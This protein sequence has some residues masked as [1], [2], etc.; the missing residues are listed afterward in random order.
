MPP[1]RRVS[2]CS[3]SASARTVTAHSLKAIG[4][5]RKTSTPRTEVP[6][7]EGPRR[8]ADSYRIPG[9]F[10][11]PESSGRPDRGLWRLFS[12]L[13]GVLHS[14]DH[15]GEIAVSEATAVG[16]AVHRRR[17]FGH[18]RGDAERPRLLEEM[19]Y[20]LEHVLELEQ[21][22]EIPLQHRSGLEVEHR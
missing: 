1:L 22:V 7:R 15:G 13:S 17:P 19:A 6:R 10:S 12:G 9:V 4:I 8:V 5:R 2:S 16:P 20:V 3:P 21:R 14:V 11:R 18:R